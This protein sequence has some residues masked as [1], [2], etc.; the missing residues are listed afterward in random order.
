MTGA[1][2][3]FMLNS[4]HKEHGPAGLLTCPSASLLDCYF[5]VK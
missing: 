5:Q 3:E 4:I 2:A 1:T